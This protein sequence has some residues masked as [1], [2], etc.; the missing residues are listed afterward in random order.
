MTR[1][2]IPA[3]TE[4]LLIVASSPHPSLGQ[5]DGSGSQLP[6]AN[7]LCVGTPVN[8]ETRRRISDATYCRGDVEMASFLTGSGRAVATATV[9]HARWVS[10]PAP[11][12]GAGGGGG[13]YGAGGTGRTREEMIVKCSEEP[14]VGR[15]SSLVA[16]LGETVALARQF[17]DVVN[18]LPTADVPAILTNLR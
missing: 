7:Y 5:G 13:V 18:H 16:L 2:L 11:S 9:D 14:P 17:R 4:R 1:K 6:E 15:G 10:L 8:N 3:S 12:G